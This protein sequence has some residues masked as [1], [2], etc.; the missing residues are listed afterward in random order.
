MDDG[1]DADGHLLSLFSANAEPRRGTVFILIYIQPSAF[2]GHVSIAQFDVTSNPFFTK[3]QALNPETSWK[4]RPTRRA[5]MAGPTLNTYLRIGIG[6]TV[7]I[8]D[9]FEESNR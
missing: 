7:F 9:Q 2:Q 6:L 1:G 4:L 8:R 3:P 5:R